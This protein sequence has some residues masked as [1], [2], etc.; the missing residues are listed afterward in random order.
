M[1]RAITIA[2]R[3][4]PKPDRP[5]ST[6]PRP[7]SHRTVMP[8]RP[9]HRRIVHLFSYRFSPHFRQCVAGANHGF[10]SKPPLSEEV[11]MPVQEPQSKE[12]G[13]NLVRELRLPPPGFNV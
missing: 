4:G 2:Q 13:L 10:L 9:A 6:D 12:H 5:S 7:T 3:S 1:H 8:V 11:S